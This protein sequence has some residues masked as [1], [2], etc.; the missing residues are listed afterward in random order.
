MNVIEARRQPIGS[1]PLDQ[2]PAFGRQPRRH[3][4]GGGLGR[5]EYRLRDARASV[6]HIHDDGSTGSIEQSRAIGL[7]QVRTAGA[8]DFDV[9]RG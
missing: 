9:A 2:V 7:N 3:D 8:N 5:F 4:V 6:P 1:Q